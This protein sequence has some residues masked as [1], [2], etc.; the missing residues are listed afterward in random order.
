MSG[1]ERVLALLDEWEQLTERGAPVDPRT[2]C[3]DCPELLPELT[4]QIEALRKMDAMLDTDE[5]ARTR[6]P[7]PGGK[8]AQ[9]NWASLDVASIDAGRY[10]PIGFHAAGGLGRI[11]LAHDSELNRDVALKLIKNESLLSAD[12]R[13]RFELEAE[14]TGRLEHPGVVPV[15]GFG[16]GKEGSP[17]YAMRFIRGERLEDAIQRFHRAD[18]HRDGGERPRSQGERSLELQTLLR[19]FLVVCQTVA[20]AHSRGVIHRDLKPANVMLGKYGETLVV[21]WGLAKAIGDAENNESH[22]DESNSEERLK[23]IAAE[24]L[25]HSLMGYAK[26]T[27]AY[28][29]PEQA[30]GRWDIVGTSSDVYSLGVILYTLLTGRRP[31]EGETQWEI[32]DKVRTGDFTP[33]RQVNSRVPAA[34]EAV[35]IKAMRK[36]PQDRYAGASDLAA[37]IEQWLADEPVKAWREPASVRA[38]RWLRR[39][40]T[41]VTGTAAAVVVA[42]IGLTSATLLLQGK[43]RLLEAAGKRLTDKNEQLQVATKRAEANFEQAHQAVKEILDQARGNPVLRGP[44]MHRAQESL[45]RVALKYYRDFLTT[46][47]DEPELQV[48]LAEAHLAIAQIIHDIGSPREAAAEN[49]SARAVLEKLL[50]RGPSDAR[51]RAMLAL[52]DS[53]LAQLDDELGEVDA[54]RVDFQRALGEY[55]RL[56]G[57]RPDDVPLRI[58]FAQACAQQGETTQDEALLQR[59]RSDVE[60]ARAAGGAP[61]VDTAVLLAQ[62]H[63]ALGVIHRLAGKLTEAA[64]SVESGAKSLDRLDTATSHEPGVE[65]LRGM[66]ELNR[67][68]LA[69]RRGDDTE[70]AESFDS[71]RGLFEHL[72]L[73]NPDVSEFQLLLALAHEALGKLRL[74]SG[75]HLQAEQQFAAVREL[76]QRL[77]AEHLRVFDRHVLARSCLDQGVSLL[78]A[79]RHAEARAFFEQ[80]QEILQALVAGDSKNPNYRR[81]LAATWNQLAS[82]ERLSGNLDACIAALK[83]ARDELASISKANPNRPE[84]RNALATACRNLGMTL[85]DRNEWE[86]A[87]DQFV[88]ARRIHDELTRQHPDIRDYRS[89]YESFLKVVVDLGKRRLAVGDD[90]PPGTREERRILEIVVD[91]LKELKRIAT[92]DADQETQLR[93]W[94]ERLEGLPNEPAAD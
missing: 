25:S 33:P 1:D 18:N 38:R 62:I 65:R 73:R 12:N 44:G 51:L 41:L 90:S 3:Q 81:D 59:A 27:S 39:H 13:R 5:G 74:A 30:D 2:L 72:A 16:L 60:A 7:D 17:Y 42:L 8:S 88:E 21:D 6:P 71:A 58:A 91:A 85:A 69:Q 94:S 49:R 9:P 77:A 45:L 53:R 84:F 11:F 56:L 67:G 55:E 10:R 40:R 35:C 29:S 20:Y 46:K 48:E 23:P 28:M 63:N 68:R 57:E 78:Q 76:L 83:K 89:N 32:I 64:A 36:L 92:L 75:D 86:G 70:A 61:P 79:D 47:G 26:G 80:S 31:F 52:V 14:I 34:L 66:L 22:S 54:N 50:V 19:S 87:W 93:Q 15:Y 24:D 82:L 37:D 4:R 43:N